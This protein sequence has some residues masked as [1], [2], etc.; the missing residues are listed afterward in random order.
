MCIPTLYNGYFAKERLLNI[1][2]I[3]SRDGTHRLYARMHVIKI[4]FINILT[5]T[6]QY[7]SV[8]KNY[9]IANNCI[10]SR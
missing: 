2:H 1:N 4:N 10:K 7:L 9:F 3:C 8:C 6:Y 5:L